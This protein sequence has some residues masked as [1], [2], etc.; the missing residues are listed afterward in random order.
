[1]GR[2]VMADQRCIYFSGACDQRRRVDPGTGTPL[3]PCETC[4]HVAARFGELCTA[5]QDALRETLATL[6][7]AGYP[8]DAVDVFDDIAYG[9]A[10]EPSPGGAPRD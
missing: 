2:A 3:P 6:E 4:P 7:R 5:D 10:A 8:P 1:M 9:E